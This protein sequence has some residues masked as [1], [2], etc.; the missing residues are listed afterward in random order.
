LKR[1]VLVVDDSRA[2]RELIAAALEGLQDPSVGEIEAVQCSSGFDALRLLPSQRFELI[3][4]DINM[5]D[6]H[7]LELLRFVRQDPR[8]QSI[9][10]VVISTEASEK[11]IQRGL[12]L[13][14][15]EYLVKPFEPQQLVEIAHRF[16][17][18]SPPGSAAS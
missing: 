18:A 10:V 3:L 11:D 7:G 9:P 13:G 17:G 5:P 2:A 1:S 8:T 14:A 4:T 6:I 12:A 16:L 15:S